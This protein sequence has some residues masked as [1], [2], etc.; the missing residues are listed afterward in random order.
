M[1]QPVKVSAISLKPIKWNK[2]SNAEKLEALF[3]EAAKDA[4]QL[5]QRPDQ[6]CIY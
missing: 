4:P 5:G 1:Y 3:V 2:A 6:H